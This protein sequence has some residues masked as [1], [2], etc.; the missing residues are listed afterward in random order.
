MAK[1]EN[2]KL[3]LTIPSELKKQLQTEGDK[4]HRSLNNYILWLLVHRHDSQQE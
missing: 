1:T 4:V 2:T 3:L